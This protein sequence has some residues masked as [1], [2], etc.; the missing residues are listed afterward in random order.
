MMTTAH[1][2][3]LVLRLCTACNQGDM[4]AI[5]E[6]L[7]PDFTDV[8]AAAGPDQF[9]A[10]IAASRRAFDDFRWEVLGLVAEGTTV[11]LRVRQLGE[12][13]GRRLSVEQVH[14]YEG[15][16]GRIASRH[17]VGGADDLFDRVA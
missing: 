16:D 6:V 10:R 7:T 12:Y 13:E 15:R 2:K 14:I 9:V 5:E 1:Y 17:C 11:A 8:A 3:Q 4:R